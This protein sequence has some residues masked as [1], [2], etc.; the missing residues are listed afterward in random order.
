MCHATLE[1]GQ[2][3]PYL[4]YNLR[5]TIN[6]QQHHRI[7]QATQAVY[8][9]EGDGWGGTFGV[10]R[11]QPRRCGGR[12]TV[13]WAHLAAWGA[14]TDGVEEEATSHRTAPRA[15]QRGRPQA[16]DTMAKGAPPRPG[17]T[18]AEEKTTGAGA[19]AAECM[20]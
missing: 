11:W 7:E 5:Q 10:M 8:E 13:L 3:I 14:A 9:Q 2:V 12:T 1:L 19:S 20:V 15:P 18:E 6:T 16:E 4:V 17:L